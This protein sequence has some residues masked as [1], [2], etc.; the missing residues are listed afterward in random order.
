ME[1][2]ISKTIRDDLIL[3]KNETL[4]DI[5]RTERD[6]LEKFK[7]EEYLMNERI[8]NFEKKFEGLN[9]KINEITTFLDSIKDI[10]SKTESLLSYKTKS[11]NS[12]IDLDIKIRSLDKET[13]DSLFFISNILKNSVIYPGIIGNTAKFKTFHNFID[14]TL[15]H[16][17]NGRQFKD[18]I[19]KEVTDNRIKQ[20][21]DVEKIKAS[22]D[23]M[24]EKTNGLIDNRINKVEENNKIIFN[25]LEERVQNLRIQYTKS[26]MS[27]N[28]MEQLINN[29]SEQIKDID[30]KKDELFLKFNDINENNKQN[31]NDINDLKE[32]YHS[33]SNYIKQIKIYKSDSEGNI[34][35]NNRINNINDDENILS[36]PEELNNENKELI[37]IKLNKKESRLKAYIKGNINIDQLEK[38][39]KITYQTIG[40]K[41]MSSYIESEE[42]DAHKKFYFSSEN[43][44]TFNS[45]PTYKGDY[46]NKHINNLNNFNSIELS[47]SNCNTI[48]SNNKNTNTDSFAKKNKITPLNEAGPE[49]LS[50]SE[51]KVK[52]IKKV[53]N[54]ISLNLEGKEIL[55]INLN[56]SDK[57]FN[58]LIQNIKTIIQD[59]NKN[60][61]NCAGFPK[62]LTNKG[63]RMIISS[64]PIYHQ[65][66]FSKKTN[67]KLLSL[68]KSIQ[69]LY[70]NCKENKT[71]L[72]KNRNI[73]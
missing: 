32:K 51:E 18:K 7:N 6:L 69:K 71:I 46:R 19:S 65:H 54:N 40:N 52:K 16:I 60:K 45:L 3:F 15:L 34:N 64:H 11:E 23:L 43:S 38:I 72:I 21:N 49:I 35:Y 17:S 13:R 50:N 27:I 61:I 70:G 22:I 36:F 30:N 44:K 9:Q 5:N 25:S 31:T 14:Y 48:R 4:K 47:N 33:L 68:N 1:E 20:I 59:N 73:E 2:G 37:K 28:K 8:E 55:N 39:N 66:K 24:L 10:K 62:I 63:E 12:I 29:F 67:P 42:K 56:N 57:K 41:K 26:D 53:G 58:N